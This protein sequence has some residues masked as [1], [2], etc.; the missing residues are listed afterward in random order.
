MNRR[1][2]LRSAIS[3]TERLSTSVQ[4]GAEFGRRARREQDSPGPP[5]ARS[6]LQNR[7][8]NATFP[9]LTEPFRTTPETLGPPQRGGEDP[10][11]ERSEER[12]GVGA[13]GRQSWAAATSAKGAGWTSLPLTRSS[14]G[15]PPLPPCGRGRVRFHHRCRCPLRGELGGRPPGSWPRQDWKLAPPRNRTF[16]H[17][18]KRGRGP[19]RR[20]PWRGRFL[21]QRPVANRGPR[22]PLRWDSRE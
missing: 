5:G 4:S 18:S 14:A 15:G 9:G 11:A 8:S 20:R 1:L 3:V 6:G 2:P 16:T 21:G 19:P 13:G 10:R 22:S 12:V 17:A 7:S